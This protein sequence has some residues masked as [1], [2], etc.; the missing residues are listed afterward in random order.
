MLLVNVSIIFSKCHNN[1]TNN[2]CSAKDSLHWVSTSTGCLHIY[3]YK[4][5]KILSKPNLVIVIH[6]DAPFNKP[7]YQYLMAKKIAERNSNCIT[8]GLLRPGYTDPDGSTSDGKKGLTTGDN[9][10]EEVI[11]SITEAIE[12]FKTLYHPNKIILVGHSGGA[13]ISAD[14]IGL[15][16]GLIDK[17]VIVSCPCNVPRWRNYMGKQQP[18]NPAW[19]DSVRSISPMDVA[20]KISTNTEVIIISG[21]KDNIAPTQLSAD[22]Y[23]ELKTNG[24][25]SRLIKV[26]YQGH[27]ILLNDSVFASLKTIIS[28]SNSTN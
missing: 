8:I 6:G 26:P 14:I 20:D 16:P 25:K 23:N 15:K 4:S 9:Y 12:H 18:E 21:M 17:A 28:Q 22:Y 27:E 11:N 24:I 2:I 5:N 10:T 1:D 19:R 13:A 3:T 7:G